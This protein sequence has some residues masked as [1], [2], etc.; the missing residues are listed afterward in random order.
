MRAPHGITGHWQ[1]GW[2]EAGLERWAASLRSRLLAPEVHLGV[3]FFSPADFS[4]V[5]ALLEILRLNA[6]IP[7]LVGASSPSYVANG[8]ELE[9]SGGLVLVLFHLPGATLRAL[10][11]GQEDLDAGAGPD[12]WHETTGIAADTVNGWLAMASP[13]RFDGETWLREWNG[14]YPGIPVVGGLSCGVSDEIPAVICLDGEAHEDGVVLIAVGGKV[15]LQPVV[16]QGCTPIGDAWTIT[17][18]DRN[19]I[20]KIGNRPAYSVLA[21]TFNGLS[22]E[23]QAKVHNNLFIGLASDEYRE[24]FHR[25]DFLIRNLLGADPQQGVLAVGALPRPGQ[26]IQF[27]WRDS[28]AA[29]E[30][31]AF[32]LNRVRAQV[33]GHTVYGGLCFFC[34]GR[35]QRL[36]GSANHDAGLI[37]EQLGPLALAGMFCNGEIGP[38]GNRSFFHGYTASLALFI[39]REPG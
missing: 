18:T 13:P 10:H 27:Q 3:V 24:D 7:L 1:G 26:T 33:V 25:G 8:L 12:F 29:T 31:L 2:D 20:L 6:R 23:S 39:S 11:L 28:A 19:Y 5:P 37:Q 22:H 15:A 17:Q 38:V 30:D 21:D 14:A 35:G 36:F 16:S 4:D 32:A 34:L 9:K